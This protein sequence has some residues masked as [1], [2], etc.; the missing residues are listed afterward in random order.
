MGGYI[1]LF[2]HVRCVPK[3]ALTLCVQIIK[4]L[5]SSERVRNNCDLPVGIYNICECLAK[6][7]LR[8]SGPG[9]VLTFVIG[10]FMFL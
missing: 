5:V 10:M 1:R 8:C 9:V 4:L 6:I 3:I 2:A 7:R